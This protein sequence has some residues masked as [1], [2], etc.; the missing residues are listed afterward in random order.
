MPYS[1]LVQYEW[2]VSAVVLPLCQ[3][4]IRLG[5]MQQVKTQEEDCKEPNKYD[6]LIADFFN[7]FREPDEKPL[8]AAECTDWH[9]DPRTYRRMKEVCFRSADCLVRGCCMECSVA[10]ACGDIPLAMK[11]GNTLPIRVR[12]VC[13]VEGPP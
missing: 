8:T 11:I 9:C 4:A 5:V 3:A 12:C 1:P 10:C 13:R 7:V 2:P 6:A